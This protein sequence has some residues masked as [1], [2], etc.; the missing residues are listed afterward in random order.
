MT[1]IEAALDRLVGAYVAAGGTTEEFDPADATE[2]DDLR[3][4]V[5]PLRL[6]VEIEHVW[7]RFQEL[8]VPGIVD[9][10]SL[11]TVELAIGAMG[12]TFQSRTLLVIGSGGQTTCFLE[13]DDPDGTGGGAVWTV[14]EFAFEMHEAA[15]SLVALIDATAIAWERGIVRLSEAHPFPWAAWDEDAW[16]R[17]KTELLPRGRVAGSRPAGWLARWLV[18]EGLTTADVTPRGPSTTIAKLLAPGVTWRG[19][20]T[21]RG[22]V[23]SA[24]SA[25]TDAVV[26]DDGTGVLAVYLPRDANPFG[27]VGDGDI[28]IDVRRFPP[29]TEVEPPYDANAFDALAVAVRDV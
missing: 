28:E 20:E 4:R 18:A 24:V 13:L 6:P 11:G 21:V 12:H 25:A 3:R 27:L 29:G 23:T 5:A 17:L 10:Q 15:P 19:T 2:L 22:R 14:E 7:R 9:T 26:I 8:G 1:T 16:R